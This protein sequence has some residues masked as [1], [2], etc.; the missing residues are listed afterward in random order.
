[1]NRQ[2]C[3]EYEK[4]PKH[5]FMKQVLGG[6]KISNNKT[7]IPR[8]FDLPARILLFP[9]PFYR[10][11]NRPSNGFAVNPLTDGTKVFP[12]L[13]RCLRCSGQN[14]HRYIWLSYITHFITPVKICDFRF[15][16]YLSGKFASKHGFP[17]VKFNITSG[18]QGDSMNT[19]MYLRK[20]RAEESTDSVD[21]TLKRHKEILL[22]Y[23]QKNGLNII[24][25]Y[26]E[27]VSGESLYTRPR[28][29]ELLANVEQ[30]DYDAVLCMDIDRLGRGAMSD[31][32][33]ILETLK[34]SG[35][36]IITPRKVY[37]LENEMD[38]TY[39]EFETFMARQE[40][41]SIKRRMQR[42]IKKTIEEGGYIANAP[43]GYRKTT[44]NKRPTLAIFEEEA[45]FVR[46][47]YDLYADKDMGCQQI[48]DTVSAMGAKPHRA[49]RFGRT[50]VMKILR[51]PVYTGKIVW[52]QTSHI[53][54]GT[55]GSP[56]HITL[57]NPKEKWIFAKGM[58]PAMIEQDLFEQVQKL[59]AEHSHPPA[60]KNT[61][62]NPLAGLVYCARCG[63]LMQRQVLRPG[64]AYLLCTNPGCMVSSSLSL[65]EQAVLNQLKGQLEGIHIDKQE[66]SSSPTPDHN[67]EMLSAVESELHTV[68]HQMQR[69]HELLEQE[70][71]DAETFHVRKTALTEKLTELKAIK[72]DISHKSTNYDSNSISVSNIY[73]AYLS[74]SC[75]KKNQ[76]LKSIINR[77]VY[78]KEK[79]AKPAEFSLEIYLKPL[80]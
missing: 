21:E 15:V 18:K 46:M 68:E 24:R 56:K 41:K 11:L 32:G 70:T 51:N 9:L 43:Y 47:M 75:Q 35:T 76:L 25:I 54:K 48:A 79:G 44:V 31:Q 40:L 64:C 72:H 77:I 78:H 8:P 10:N 1:M 7:V 33:I 61:L 23:A 50:S 59:F 17:K 29:L 14:V 55:K 38:E 73:L 19:A 65:V 58:H 60:K 16:L 57:K 3:L 42:G 63:Q 34:N 37:D 27:V 6:L 13:S 36:K 74:A 12:V 4:Y 71:Y 62:E 2:K 69:L 30:G 39:S 67:I 66:V 49:N 53:R 26:E 22:D 5:Q 20:S 52:N 80:Y 45:R 28:M